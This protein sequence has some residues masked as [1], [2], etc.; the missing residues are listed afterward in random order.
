MPSEIEKSAT[1]LKL[2]LMNTMG[3]LHWNSLIGGAFRDF[4]LDIIDDHKPILQ[5]GEPPKDGMTYLGYFGDSG[6]VARQ[7][8]VPIHWRDGGG[9]GWINSTSGHYVSSSPIYWCKLPD[10][11]EEFQ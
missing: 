7:D 1:R 2:K 3:Q 10:H 11:P 8:I 5:K 6:Y 4:Y 9:D